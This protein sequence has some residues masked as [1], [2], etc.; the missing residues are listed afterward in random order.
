MQPI[1]RIHGIGGAREGGWADAEE[2]GEF[3]VLG[4]WWWSILLR[5]ILEVVE[6]SGHHVGLL[7]EDLGENGVGVWW[8]WRRW[9]ALVVV[10]V[11][12]RLVAIIGVNI[13][14]GRHHLKTPHRTSKQREL[15]I[16]TNHPRLL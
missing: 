7:G 4:R 6:E 3:R 11:A 15:T 10:V 13:S 14:P 2:F 12:F 8:W 1:Q 16:K 9:V 5:R